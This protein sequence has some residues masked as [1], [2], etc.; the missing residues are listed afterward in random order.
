MS[1]SY[2]LQKEHPCPHCGRA[3]DKLHIGTSSAGWYF[4]LHVIPELGINTLDDWR[5]LWSAPDAVI[6]DEYGRTMSVSDMELSIT[7]R[8]GALPKDRKG[9]DSEDEVH[10]VNYSERGD[11]WLLRSRLGKGCV[12]HGEGTWSYFI[13]E[14]S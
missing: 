5:N 12:G 4:A 1:C 3:Y 11:N 6:L 7:A 8:Q 14:F 2:Y 10:R 13:G 9:R